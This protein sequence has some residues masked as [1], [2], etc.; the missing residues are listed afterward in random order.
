[1]S[2]KRIGVVRFPYNV[3]YDRRG[4]YL[5][6]HEPTMH[7]VIA[8]PGKDEPNDETRRVCFHAMRALNDEA[9]RLH[10]DNL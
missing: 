5:V 3:Y 8:L 10:G 6:Q 9:K 4:H 7:S 1:M 2:M